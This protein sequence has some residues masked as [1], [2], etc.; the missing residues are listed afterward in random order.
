M[1]A[2]YSVCVGGN[3]GA[4]LAVL[5]I[6]GGAK[7]RERFYRRKERSLHQDFRRMEGSLRKKSQRG[8]M[9]SRENLVSSWSISNFCF[10]YT[11]SNDLFS[12]INKIKYLVAQFKIKNMKAILLF[13]PFQ[14]YYIAGIPHP[15][16]LVSS[17]LLKMKNVV[18]GKNY[19][20]LNIQAY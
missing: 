9:W 11:S 6:L 10:G 16:Q 13:S 4:G 5:K 14:Y 15:H 7:Q 18:L 8:K 1:G 17:Q 2:V 19:I 20:F 12:V 3:T